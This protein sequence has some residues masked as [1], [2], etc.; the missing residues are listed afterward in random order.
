M[1]TCRV[2]TTTGNEEYKM[3]NT[4][5]GLLAA[6]AL[7]GAFVA[8]PAFAAD[9]PKGDLT[10]SGSVA[11][12]TDYRFRGVSQTNGD[13]AVQGSINLNHSSGAYV[14]VW[15]SSISGGAVYGN[16]EVDIYGGYTKEVTPGVT[17]DVGLLYYA[18]PGGHVGKAEFFEP[19]ASLSTTYGPAKIKLGVNYAWDQAAIGNDDNIYVYSNVDVAVPST[20]LTLSAHAGYQDGNLSAP[21]LTGAKKRHGWDYSVGASA[22]VLGKVTLG[23]AYVGVEGPVVN[24]FTDDQ[25]VGTLSVAF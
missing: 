10:V 16:Q 25:V 4:I 11:L 22:T 7:A 24:R 8:A 21:A 20:P 2:R 23:V 18:Y 5:R 14:G 17:A 9:A 15:S 6:S 12:V 1:D 3:T 19:Y 13:A